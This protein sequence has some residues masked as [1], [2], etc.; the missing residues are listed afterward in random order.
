MNSPRFSESTTFSR[1][2]EGR[3]ICNTFDEALASTNTTLRPDARPF[4]IIIVGG[5]TFGAALASALFERDKER[6]HRILVLEG[7]PFALHEHVQNIPLAGFGVPKAIHLATI[8]T[9]PNTSLSDA[10]F[11]N[12]NNDVWGLPWHSPHKFPGLAYCVGGRS[13]FW[14]G[15]SPQLLGAEMPDTHWPASVKTELT[16]RYF[17]EASEQ[18]GVTETNDFIHGELHTELRQRLFDGINGAQVTGAISLAQLDLNLDAVPAGQENLFK[19][20]APLAVKTRDRS[21]A[22][23]PNKFSAV[24][25]LVKAA[26][27]AAIESQNDDV[28]KR[29]MIVPNC[30]VTR[31]STLSR[32]VPVMP[33]PT[34]ENRTF[35]NSVET[36]LG[37]IPV[38][39]G[40]AVII[41]L[42]TIESTR[43]A[44]TSFDQPHYGSNLMAHLRSNYTIRIPRSALNL[45]NSVTDLQSSALFM[46]GRH[47]HADGSTGHFHLQIT[48][49]GLDKPNAG[50]EA[51]LFMKI[52]DLDMLNTLRKANDQFVIITMRGIGEMEPNNPNS[53][54]HLDPQTDE[55]GMQRA[56]VGLTPSLKDN[57]LWATMDKA[58]EDVG[59]LF[60][61]GDNMA[62]LEKA[63]DGLGTTH[64]ETG[65]LWMGNDPTTSVT[66]ADCRFHQIHNT[67]VAG[68]ALFP[69]IGSPNPMLTG[70][71]LVR[72]LARKLIPDISDATA[73]AGFKPLFNGHSLKGWTVTGGGGFNVVDGALESFNNTA[74]L[75]LL[76]CHS[77]TP[78]NYTLRL[79]WRTFRHEDNS[80]VFVRFP[81]PGNKGYDNPAWVA[82]NFGFEVQ[83][84]E[85]G[86]P[87]GAG[88]HK[89][90]A[91]Y[92]ESTQ[93]LTQNPARPLGEWNDYEINVTN[94]TYTVLLNG[95]Q[96]TTFTN[97]NPDRGKP[98]T[99]K[100]PSYIGLQAYQG[101]RVQFRN[102]R[103]TA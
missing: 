1:D 100:I 79:E 3:Y 15:W 12:W 67:Y 78:A 91:I 23:P 74:D 49:S 53:F 93:T 31:L 65:T 45:P 81:D 97:T 70:I 18:I 48:A 101:Q 57:A 84:D 22:F 86:K 88:I 10:T 50:S 30:H 76:W 4:D 102:V 59:K 98:S 8:Q 7:G 24:P 82:V 29:L 64:H 32:L 37:S 75:G 69:T 38:V 68:P 39:D 44:K 96:V 20:E 94:Q 33:A 46:K 56:F 62:I 40:G 66:N 71:A 9:W 103:I 27:T 11:R 16:N 17:R 43:L 42:G 35:V 13:V 95:V 52:P 99:S 85:L 72:R 21:G 80:G 25:M 26:R 87:D 90:G 5:G 14:G 77:P 63:R 83:I 41:A 2:I 54:V 55:F 51:E 36:N 47:T 92:N 61:A 19:L 89:T 34:K 6:K 28:K 58:A 73:E 60:A